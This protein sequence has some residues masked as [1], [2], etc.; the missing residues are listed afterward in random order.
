MVEVVDFLKAGYI[1][2]SIKHG[3]YKFLAKNVSYHVS[4]FFY[5]YYFF[6][7]GFSYSYNRPMAIA[8]F[9][10]KKVKSVYCN[11]YI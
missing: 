4:F 9:M 2:F 3:D 8:G 7:I 10:M 1:C 5:Y 11:Q 6:I